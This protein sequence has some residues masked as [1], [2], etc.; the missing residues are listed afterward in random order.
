VSGDETVR[1]IK[2]ALAELGY[3]GAKVW[4]EGSLTSWGEPRIQSTG[5]P[6][7]VLWQAY[8]TAGLRMACWS[9]HRVNS[10]DPNRS[11]AC[12]R[13]DCADLGPR[14]PPRELLVSSS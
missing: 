7:A 13:G 1:R 8:A 14:C 2:T 10:G 4:P 9:C 5:A 11:N 12:A 6:T 3:V